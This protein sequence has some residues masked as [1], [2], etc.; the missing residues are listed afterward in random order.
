MRVAEFWP[1]V[2]DAGVQFWKDKGPRLGAALAFYTTLSLSPLLLVVIAIAGAVFGE[3]AARGEMQQQIQGMV[4]EDGAKFIEGMLAKTRSSDT[5]TLMTIVGIATLLIGA[6]GVFA[7]L[8]DALNTVWDVK[9]NQVRGGIWGAIRDRLLSFSVV[10]GLAFL[11][12]VSLSFSAALSALNGWLEDR[13]PIGGLGPPGRQSGSCVPAHGST[14]RIHL[15]GSASR[16]AC[17]VGRLGRG[18]DHSRP[19]FPWV[20]ISSVSI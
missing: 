7:E 15:Q 19:V 12:L 16:Q 17:L 8:Q 14:L 4:G 20:N 9:P 11:L 13:L 2:K 3:Q 5:S 18:F 1:L 10:C 6:S